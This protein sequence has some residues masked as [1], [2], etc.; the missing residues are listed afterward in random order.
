MTLTIKP[1][2]NPQWWVDCSYAMHQDMKSHTGIS[3]SIGK[4]GAYTSS[5]KQKLDT[6]SSTE[7]K[8][9]AIDDAMSQ[10]LTAREL[11]LLVNTIYQDN[12]SKTTAALSYCQKLARHPVVSI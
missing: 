3:M 6:K 1:N 12:S 5:C 7:A 11:P 2:D 4:G 10:I 9:V 8:L